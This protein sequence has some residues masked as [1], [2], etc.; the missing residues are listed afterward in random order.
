MISRDKCILLGTLAKP[1]GVNGS[2]VLRGSGLKI[3]KIKGTAFID[4]DGLLVPFFITTAR[5]RSAD[6]F[7]VS[8]EDIN[9]Q[10][11][12]EKLCGLEVFRP[13][14]ASRGKKSHALA[15]DINGYTV[16]D[17]NSGFSGTAT[18][19]LEAGENTLLRVTANEH[20]YFIP[21]H[22]DIIINIDHK[23]KSITVSAP[24]GLFEL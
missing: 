20:E 22:E 14:S 16:T 6:E 17:T 1:H 21:F 24:D 15:R 18:D 19:I 11:M 3:T 5:E 9:S 7:I 13:S 12:A 23:V 8:F 4:I 10:A 2:L